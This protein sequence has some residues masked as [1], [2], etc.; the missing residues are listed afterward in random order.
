MKA[1]ES[2]GQVTRFDTA[3]L[4]LLASMRKDLGYRMKLQI[5][6]SSFTSSFLRDRREEGKALGAGGDAIGSM[7]KN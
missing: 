6:H 2:R 5:V 1:T 7:T 4:R 3:L